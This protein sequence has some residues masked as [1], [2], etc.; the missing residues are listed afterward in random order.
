MS[1]SIVPIV[2]RKTCEVAPQRFIVSLIRFIIH[3]N[4]VRVKGLSWSPRLMM[5]PF[6]PRGRRV[7]WISF[8]D[9]VLYS[10]YNE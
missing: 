4:A 8:L 2:W 1:F 7:E 10:V 9:G 3:L 6:S 5:N